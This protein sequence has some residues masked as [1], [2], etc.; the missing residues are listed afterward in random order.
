MSQEVAR[1]SSLPDERKKIEIEARYIRTV[2]SWQEQCDL[3][4]RLARVDF[5]AKCDLAKALRDSEL[6][7]IEREPQRT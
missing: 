3:A 7:E 1:I 5:K 4:I 6:R 2:A